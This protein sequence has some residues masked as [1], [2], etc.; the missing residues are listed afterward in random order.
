[1]AP[2]PNDDEAPRG[3]LVA[4]RG[5]GRRGSVGGARCL[6]G[7][8]LVPALADLFDELVAEGREVVRLAARHETVVDVHLL[9]DPV[10]SRVADVGL[11]AR[12][13]RERAV[14]DDVGLD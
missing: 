3:R 5:C 4:G 2:T 1:M 7:L 11:Q 12:P 13:G 6:E 8:L 9:V 10:A 14:A